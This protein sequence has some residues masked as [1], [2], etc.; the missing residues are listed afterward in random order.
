MAVQFSAIS[1]NWNDA[2]WQ[3]VDSTSYLKSEAAS[4]ATTTS[5]VASAAFT[6]G[7][8]TVEG[9]LLR[10]KGTTTTPTGTFS[11]ELFN[12]TGASSVATVTCNATD[13]KNNNTGLDGGW[14]YFKFGSPVTL[15]AATNYQVRIKTSVA[16]TVTVYRDATAGNWSKGLVTSTTAFL[17]ASDDII[18]CGNI[19]AASTTAVNTVTF[20]NTA[21]T[22][23]ASLEVGAYGKLVGQNSAS[24]NYVLNI[25]STGI[26]R[27]AH[28]GIVEFSTTS[29]R[30]PSS[31]TF[32]ITMTNATNGNNFID[33]RN[34]GTFRAVGATKTRFDTLNAN[35]AVSATSLTTSTSTGWKSGDNIGIAGTGGISQQQQRTL[36]VDASGTTLTIS[37]GLTNATLGTSPTQAHVI[38]LTSNFKIQGTSTSL[39]TYVKGANT[40]II[41]LDQIEFQFTGVYNIAPTIFVSTNTNSENLGSVTLTKCTLWNNG[42]GLIGAASNAL[43][44]GLYVD[45]C[46]GYT[47]QAISLIVI[48]SVPSPLT[49]T[50][51][52]YFKNC[53]LIGGSDGL[54]AYEVDSTYVTIDNIVATNA[55]RGGITTYGYQKPNGKT[56]N[57]NYCTITNCKTYSCTVGFNVLIASTSYTAALTNVSN[58]TAFRCTYGIYIGQNTINLNFDTFTLF[59][60]STAN[61]RIGNSSDCKFV[62]GDIQAGTGVVCPIGV[63]FEVGTG[64]KNI[65]FE[66]CNFGTTT[67]HTNGDIN[68]DPFTTDILFNN[69]TCSS[70]TLVFQPT[71]IS[72]TSRIRF[73]R[74]NGTAGNHKTYVENGV[75]TNDTTI[76]DGSPNSLRLTPNVY[77]IQTGFSNYKL[78]STIFQIAVANATTA[79]ISV[80]VRKSVIGDGTAYNGNQPRLILKSNPSA[81]STYN[82]DIVCATASAAPGIWETLSYTLPSAVI[83]N[84]GMEF[85]IDCDGTTGWINID[86]FVSSNNNSMSYYMNGEPISDVVSNEKSFTFVG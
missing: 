53:V 19:T 47:T 75:L 8:I 29:S 39:C 37:S 14:V 84:V 21:A 36:S 82:N 44:A 27:V 24:T 5:Y 76:Y 22:T 57:M 30:L 6:P 41:E 55:T 77:L 15:L 46:V 25:A 13:I 52:S 10:V 85:Y 72:G 74:L 64:R 26:F 50:T 12:S 20:N 59:S 81:G 69:C 38:N 9:I 49:S 68:P 35:A 61:I 65:T 1:N 83:D 86:T 40:S 78:K 71:S 17:S 45:G 80:K 43:I 16:G 58:F 48:N 62:N 33:V 66:R 51:S 23:Y 2:T 79:T 34:F 63:V 67:A 28:N 32:V 60:N 31:S 4:T 18:I 56:T 7:V 73:Q 54:L 11:V 42:H 70:S 3:T